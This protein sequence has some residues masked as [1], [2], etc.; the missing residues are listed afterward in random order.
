MKNH[1]KNRYT[2][3]PN[4][5]IND[6]ELHPIARFLFVYLCSK[7]DDWEFHTKQ[8]EKAL[9]ISK[10]TRIKYTKELIDAGWITA[11]QQKNGGGEWG[12]MEIELHEL[13]Q[14]KK[15]DTVPPQQEFTAAEIYG[16]G[17]NPLHNN[18]DLLSNT[19]LLNNTNSEPPQKLFEIPAI[20]KNKPKKTM[21]KNSE[22]F[23]LEICKKKLAE[24]EKLGIDIYYYFMAISNW[25][26]IKPNELR[27][28]NGWIATF[29][30]FISKDNDNK[31]VKFVNAPSQP[32]VSGGMMDYLNIQ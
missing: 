13:P 23:D 19:N 7:P 9:R 31:K 11:T 27:T 24:E 20:E 17:K 28:A 5:V 32:A 21:F 8:I 25:S 4:A 3:I 16:S 14:R 6:I 29:R 10:D 1:L 18:T 15:T 2:Q 26:E 22:V 12:S 30:T